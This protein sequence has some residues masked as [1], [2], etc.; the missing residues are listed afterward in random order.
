MARIALYGC[1]A[2]AAA[3]SSFSAAQEAVTIRQAVDAAW[4]K[5][6]QLPAASGRVGVARARRLAA[7]SPWAAPPSLDILNRGEP[8]RAS[9]AGQRETEVGVAWPLLLPGQRSAR[10]GSADSEL[11]SSEA[12]L[13]AAKLAIAGE[14]R[15]AAWT[16]LARE[17]ELALAE[18][19]AK[20]LL[21]LAADV[22][23]R[24]AAG[25]LARADSLAARAEALAASNAAREAAPRLEAARA[26]WR[27]LTGL[28]AVP[29]ALEP[30]A[31]EVSPDE[32]PE[33]AAATLRLE[34]ARKRLDLTRA[35]R[36]DPPELMLRY[37]N[38]VAASGLPSQNSIGVAV[39]IPFATDS[40]NAP[41]EAAVLAEVEVALA[42]ERRTRERLAAELA[43]AKALASAT[44]QQ[45]AQEESRA[46]LLRERA[47]LIDRSFRAGETALPE[48]LRTLSAAAQAE[49]S[50]ARQRAELGLARARVQQAAG[51][52]P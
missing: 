12:G 25:D 1:C 37:R 42:E 14:V 10:I 30:A 45:V 34:T 5:S 22:D 19:Q 7:D 16:V 49:S 43:S 38:E 2:L 51:V 20:A 18:S 33:M 28:P 35:E 52:L 4:E 11:G 48:L 32:H 47:R 39:R 15:E 29:A 26:R 40:R 27:V 13:R 24:V 46:A 50:L 17:A 9:A 31:A 6:V 41:R 8:L 44:E 21:Q 23:R 3:I 36:R